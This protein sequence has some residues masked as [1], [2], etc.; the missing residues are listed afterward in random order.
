MDREALAVSLSGLEPGPNTFIAFAHLSVRP[1]TQVTAIAYTLQP[2]PGTVSK[3]VNVSY[4]TAWLRSRG[5]VTGWTFTVPVFGLYDGFENQGTFQVEIASQPTQTLPF[6]ITTPTY[7]D[8][9]G[10]YTHPTIL[11]ARSAGSSLGFDFFAIKS[12]VDPVVVIDTDGAIRWVGTGVPSDAVLFQNNGFVV[13][14]MSS[15]KGQR[16][17]FDGTLTS[18]SVSDPTVVDFTHNVDPGKEGSLAEFDTTSEIDATVEEIGPVGTV[19]HAWD[20]GSLLGAYMAS[21]GDDPSLFVRPDVDWFHLNA[22]TYDPSDDSLIVSSRENFLIKI[23]YASGEPIWILGDPNKYWFTFPSLRAKALQLVDG[24]LY[25]IGQ[26]A[27]SITSDGLV[28]V[29][30]DGFQSLNQPAGAPPGASRPYSTVSA[31]SIDMASRTA[32]EVWDF[33]DGMALDSDFCGSA[34][35]AG[36]KSVLVDYAIAD[37]AADARLLGLDANHDVVFEFA[38]LDVGGCSSWNAVPVPLDDMHFQ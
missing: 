14:S 16:N 35:E 23:D 37:R 17:E 24:G 20:M 25:P 7:I 6:T 15:G 10:I 12:A 36:G 26:H 33:N 28:M 30:N 5:Y 38:Y 18:W 19:L 9:H 27:T 1:P 29:F 8:P 13:G 2:R 31:Y 21:Q 22:S 34:Y 4:T 32:Q 3:P 11:Q